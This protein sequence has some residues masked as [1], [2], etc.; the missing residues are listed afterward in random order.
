[1]GKTRVVDR[2]HNPTDTVKRLL[3]Y[4]LPFKATLILMFFLVVIHTATTVAGPFLMG[5]A[6]DQFIAA[7]KL[8]G[9][10]RISLV[11]LVLYLINWASQAGSAYL[12][13]GISQKALK[14][15]RKELFDHLQSMSI[16]FFDQNPHGELMSRLTNDIDAINQ[17]ISQ[18]IIQLFSSVLTLAGVIIAMFL[19]NMWLALTTMIA[20]PM[21]LWLVSA[22]TRHTRKS[23]RSLQNEIGALNGLMEENISGLR[24]VKIFHR[25]QTALE[26]FESQNKLVCDSAIKAQTLAFLLMPLMTVLSNLN[27]AIVAGVGS[28]MVI[29]GLAS[30]GNIA[31]FITYT[32]T[33][34]QPLR[35]ISNLI[36]TI[37][38]AIAGAER[39]FD[40]IDQQPE[41][42]DISNPIPLEDVKGEVIFKDVNFE[43]LPGQPVIKKMNIHAKPGQMV[44]LVGPTGAGKTTLVNLLSRFY[45]LHDG[46]IRIDGINIQHIK[47]AD[48]R[49]QLGIVLQDAFL[50]SASVIENIR[51][52][53]LDASDEACYQAAK[54]ANADFFIR[55]LPQG[56]H[57]L[58][59]ERG[60]NLSQ[61]QRQLLT[62]ARAVLADPAILVLDEATSSVDTRTE[63]R[64]QQALQ[65]LMEGRTSFVIAHRLST[66]RNADQVLVIQHGE[67]LEQGDHQMLLDAEG[68]Y[69]DLYYSQFKGTVPQ[70]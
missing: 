7:G 29:Q 25:N 21:M 65:R 9:L 15:L 13:A 51:Y 2:V 68:F 16:R 69:H 26:S 11:M 31:S 3:R 49:Q 50:F 43:Y 1:M 19:L 34:A 60:S 70:G 48:L 23:F 42:T 45:N 12:T 22:V 59:S 17:A 30:V 8:D 38:A 47:Q 63:I 46:E 62:I 56:Y 66:I 6:I 58:L 57:T 4:F 53:R 67:I 39:I 40:I 35:Q 55:R 5:Y 41:L 33:F 10:L 37:Q 32:R 28:W 36:N 64:I 44:A 14:A 54:V 24:E 52:G 27:I 18:N 61:G 20:I